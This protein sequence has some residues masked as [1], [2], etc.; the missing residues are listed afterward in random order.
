MYVL[1]VTIGGIGQI[2]AT[3]GL[4]E[5]VRSFGMYLA[6]SILVKYFPVLNNS[7]GY[8]NIML[9][10]TTNESIWFKNK[11]T[12]IAMTVDSVF[13]GIYAALI[14]FTH[15]YITIRTNS[16]AVCYAVVSVICIFSICSALLLAYIDKYA[17]V[18]VGTDEEKDAE[19]YKSFSLRLFGNL[20]YPFWVLMGSHVFTE[21][22]N[23]LVSNVICAYMSDR[24]G[25][26]TEAS[27][28]IGGTVPF[29][30]SLL[31]LPLGFVIYKLG[32]KVHIGTC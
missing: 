20:G 12:A 27:G 14:F 15:P 10:S 31:S 9:M 6:G 1:I 24:F 8:A 2:I 16:P 18:Y 7:V 13:E 30:T 23:F 25:L 32:H 5:S 19:M 21:G 4:T 17:P 3:I 26:S 29:V 11:E 22:T 28:Y